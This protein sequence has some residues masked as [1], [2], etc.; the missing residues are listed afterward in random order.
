MLQIRQREEFGNLLKDLNLNGFGI[1]IGVELAKFSKVI[2]DSSGLKKL[3]LLDAWKTFSKEESNGMIYLTQEQQDSN[4]SHVINSMNNY[5]DR[6]SIIRK[7]S[8]TTLSDF[9]DGYFDF[10]YID[11]SHD[12]EHVKRDILGWYPKVKSN[13]L[14]AGHD[15]LDGNYRKVTYGVKRAVDEFCSGV[16]IVPLC[17]YEKRN[18][19][20]YFI[21]P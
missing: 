8:I 5:G 6:V 14:F 13:G 15:Y 18:P 21:K 11:A 7:D 10:I 19:S 1:E 3:Y 2:I 9:T 12:Y 20:W 16:N 4:Y 17:T